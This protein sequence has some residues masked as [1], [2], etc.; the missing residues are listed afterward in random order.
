MR[1]SLHFEN[2]RK[3]YKNKKTNISWLEQP[4]ISKERTYLS[5]Q[6]PVKEWLHYLLLDSVIL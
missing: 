3:I 2:I 1:D 4:F 5:P 6:N